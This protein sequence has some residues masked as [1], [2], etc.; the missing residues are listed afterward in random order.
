M[1]TSVADE[2][3]RMV[4]T[5][6]DD[7]IVTLFDGRTLTVPLSWYPRLLH[8]TED[9]RGDWRLIGAGY[10]IHWPQIDEDLSTEGLLRG[11]V[12]PD[13]RIHSPI[14]DSAK[15]FYGNALGQA[16]GQLESSRTELE[17][18][19]EQLPEGQE[20]AISKIQE[21]VDSYDSIINA[22]DEAAQQ[23]GVEDTVNDA[24]QQ[25][26][27]IQGATNT[28]RQRA[29]ELGVDLT[30]MEGSGAKEVSSTRV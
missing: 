22:L 20:K 5:T 14:V 12:A 17:N 15:D 24:V 7:L 16:K 9:Q 6:D 1:T 25:T 11:I 4:H 10:G 26:G 18:L 8:A 3:I 2:R 13:A 29:E 30:Q 19:L 27:E 28:A 23:G 21:L